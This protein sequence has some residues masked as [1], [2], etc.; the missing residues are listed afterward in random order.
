MP[1]IPHNFITNHAQLVKIKVLK[2]HT[3]GHTI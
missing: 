3:D 2:I 1:P